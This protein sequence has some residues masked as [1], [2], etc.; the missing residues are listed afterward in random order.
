MQLIK[1]SSGLS[2]F[3]RS[4]SESVSASPEYKRSYI[5]IDGHTKYIM[6]YLIMVRVKS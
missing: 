2:N 5:E 6:I 3:S 4:V 1:K